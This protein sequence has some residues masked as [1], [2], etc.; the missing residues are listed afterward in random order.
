L[1]EAWW[2]R[3]CVLVIWH[4]KSPLKRY[5]GGGLGAAVGDV[6]TAEV[7]VAVCA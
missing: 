1:A 5:A 3:V 2:Q 6:E 7:G 4:A